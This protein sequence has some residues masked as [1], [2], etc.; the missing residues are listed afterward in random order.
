MFL[1]NVKQALGKVVG[2]VLLT[3]ALGLAAPAR[4]LTSGLP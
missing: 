4:P 3:S 1:R 2:A